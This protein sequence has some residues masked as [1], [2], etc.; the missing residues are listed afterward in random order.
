MKRGRIRR[1]LLGIGAVAVPSGA[2]LAWWGW[3]PHAIEGRVH[4]LA[5]RHEMSAEVAGISPGLRSV[6]VGRLALRRDGVE[7]IFEDVTVDAGPWALASEGSRAVSRIEIGRAE[8]AF[9]ERRGALDSLEA[10]RR[11]RATSEGT[12]SGPSRPL[13]RLEIRR[14]S[15]Q[16]ESE[17]ARIRARS[18]VVVEDGRVSLDDLELE[19][20]HD[21][22]WLMSSGGRISLVR[23]DG[24]RVDGAHLAQ[25][26]W[27]SDLEMDRELELAR[28]FRGGRAAGTEEPS[29]QGSLLDRL[30]DGATIEVERFE[31]FRDDS[32]RAV[33]SVAASVSR[34]GAELLSRGEGEAQDGALRWDI[35]LEPTALRASGTVRVD[36]L[37][38]DLVAPFGPA[39]P[40][41]QPERG[42]ISADLTL[43]VP[44]PAE[45]SLRGFAAVRG[46][47]ISTP[48]VAPHPIQGLDLRA[49]GRA[50]WRPIERRLELESAEVSMGA[51]KVTVEGALELGEARWL[52]SARASLPAT[53]CNDVL[54]ALPR[55]LMQEAADFRWSGR[56]GGS[57]R[58]ELDSSA[59]SDTRLELRVADACRFEVVP[60]MA[61]LRRFDGPFLHRV[62]EPDGTPFE[63]IAGPGSPDWVPLEA[64]HPF[65]VHSVIAHEDAGFFRHSGFAVHA[66]RD[67]L[68]R[69]VREGRYVVGASTISMQLAKNLFLAREKTLARKLQEVILTWWIESAL[70]KE[71]ILELYLNVIEYAP[72]VYGVGRGVEHYF[73]RHPRELT[74]AQAAYIA[75][76]LPGPKVYHEHYIRGDLSRSMRGRVRRFLEHLRARER[77]DEDALADGLAELEAFRFDRPGQPLPARAPVGRAGPLPYEHRG[78]EL[79]DDGEAG[80][81]EEEEMGEHESY[82]LD[83]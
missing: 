49:E 32:E 57:L 64:I 67:A 50:R 55:D 43:D 11:G 31:A 14:A 10:I 13:P 35:T 1:W 21:V 34:R 24:L 44:S 17:D 8:V 73:G 75:C 78:L 26:S 40:W 27:R 3:L 18:R 60:A 30:V 38:F 29:G 65:L 56:I 63:M 69:N 23:G 33:A 37:P 9:D 82:E 59:L 22:P 25:V 71:R 51:A 53:P 42:R 54:L 41:W 5:A 19:L 46:L 70:T 48:R 6:S 45:V 79:R 76:I 77:I 36:E 28:R 61:D 74:A 52:V 16:V 39:L 80:W 20:G 7:A 4:E 47:A 2:A 66:I 68:A 12:T 15:L 72:G 83:D 81:V 58:L 62:V